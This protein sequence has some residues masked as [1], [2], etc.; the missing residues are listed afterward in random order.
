MHNKFLVVDGM[1]VETGSFNY[2]NAAEEKNAENVIILRS[3]RDIA[4]QYLT[5]W[6]ELWDESEPYLISAFSST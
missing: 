1:T 2:T 6:Q 5:R 3:H 4:E